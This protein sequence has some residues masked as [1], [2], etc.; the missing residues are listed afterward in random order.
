METG[1]TPIEIQILYN[2]RAKQLSILQESGSNAY[3]GTPTLVGGNGYIGIMTVYGASDNKYITGASRYA[4]ATGAADA[5]GKV[6]MNKL[7]GYS[8][9]LENGI[10]FP[11]VD[12]ESKIPVTFRQTNITGGGNL[13]PDGLDLGVFA[14]ES[15]SE[16]IMNWQY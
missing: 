3:L 5:F 1:Y 16:I 12:P 15:W 10:P 4:G 6:G 7:G 2:W 13:F 14:G 9:R 11:F 8:A